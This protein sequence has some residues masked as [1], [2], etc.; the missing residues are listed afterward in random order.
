VEPYNIDIRGF[1]LDARPLPDNLK[2][3][4][5]IPKEYD[6]N[7]KNYNKCYL[8]SKYEGN[9]TKGIITYK[10]NPME[11]TLSDILG[12]YMIDGN[13]LEEYNYNNLGSTDKENWICIVNN[14]N[15]GKNIL[16]ISWLWDDNKTNI[17]YGIDEFNYVSEMNNIYFDEKNTYI[18]DKNSDV[19]YNVIKKNVDKMY[20]GALQEHIGKK[21][22]N[23]T[24]RNYRSDGSVSHEGPYYKFDVDTIL[25]KID[26]GY[27]EYDHLNEEIINLIP[28]EHYKYVRY[29]NS[30]VDIKPLTWILL[31][32]DYSRI[33][34]RIINNEYPKWTLTLLGDEL[35]PD[36]EFQKDKIIT[37]HNGLYFTY[38]F[39]EEGF[40]KIKLELIDINGNKYEFEKPIVIV[41][42]NA[43]YEMYHTLKD[44][45][46]KYL[47]EKNERS[48]I[49][50]N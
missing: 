29:I 4:L 2:Y 7:V 45:Y 26:K 44:E 32:F 21:D 50:I 34:G 37:T 36:V 1:Y 18:P 42:K 31:G 49:K 12:E 22:V 23:S 39:E 27:K 41:D 40:Y 14:E 13:G 16:K 25:Y 8:W 19:I 3:D 6:D 46:D 17:L 10:R 35:D 15:D 20:S 38:L 33:T 28:G 48:L 47:E 11:I 5:I 9:G 24:M 43:N 30:V